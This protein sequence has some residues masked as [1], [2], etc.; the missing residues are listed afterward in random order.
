MSAETASGISPE[1]ESQRSRSRSTTETIEDVSRIEIVN[2]HLT[3]ADVRK[4]VAD[5]ITDTL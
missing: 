2:D 4:L 1:Q 3:A 5:G